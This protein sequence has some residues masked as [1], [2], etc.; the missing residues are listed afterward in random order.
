MRMPTLPIHD[1]SLRHVGLTDAVGAGYTEAGAERAVV[2]ALVSTTTPSVLPLS[3]ANTMTIP[4]LA[5]AILG[6]AELRPL[7]EEH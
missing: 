2:A 1:L 3:R 7:A 6:H 4:R 5:S